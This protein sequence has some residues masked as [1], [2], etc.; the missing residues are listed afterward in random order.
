MELWAAGA[1]ETPPIELLVLEL[2]FCYPYHSL[3]N[4]VPCDLSFIFQIF[5]FK[6]A[7]LSAAARSW[8]CSK[9]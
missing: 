2:N 7:R 6:V 1:F 9:K 5:P 3:A 8:G 4:V